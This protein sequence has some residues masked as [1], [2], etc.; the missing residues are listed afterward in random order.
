LAKISNYNNN[1]NNPDLDIDTDKDIEKVVEFNDTGKPL[2][3]IKIKKQ[4]INFWNHV[5]GLLKICKG[6]I[7]EQEEKDLF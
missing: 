4:E 2:Q 1:L 5:Y 7:V 6:E 3:T